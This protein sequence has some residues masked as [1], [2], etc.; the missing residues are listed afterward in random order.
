MYNCVMRKRFS[1]NYKT[2]KTLAITEELQ[3]YIDKS[4]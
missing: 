4:N 2:L 1:V 3:K